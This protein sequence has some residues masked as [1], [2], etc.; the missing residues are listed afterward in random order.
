MKRR[1]KLQTAAPPIG[2]RL[3]TL[4][5][6]ADVLPLSTRTMR[7]YLQLGEIELLKQSR[8]TINMCAG[9]TL[10]LCDRRLPLPTSTN[11]SVVG[12]AECS[13][14]S[15]G[16]G[17]LVL[18]IAIFRGAGGSAGS[19]ILVSSELKQ[20]ARSFGKSRV[21]WGVFVKIWTPTNSNVIPA[22]LHPFQYPFCA[23]QTPVL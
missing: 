13:A 21:F 7:D 22:V 9:H 14:F 17:S 15:A 20:E 1:K 19:A 23:I 12:R 8:E 10:V 6:A 3:L 18:P 2:D 11:D 4:R 5:E 16:D